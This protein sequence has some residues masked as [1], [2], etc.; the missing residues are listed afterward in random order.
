MNVTV[1]KKLKP[2]AILVHGVH[3]IG[4][5]N[6]PTEAPMPIFIGSEENDEIECA[7]L[8]K[9]EN[10]PDF[11]KQLTW[12]RDTPDLPYRTVVI[13][14]VDTL[15]QVA[16]KEILKSQNGKTMATAFGGYGKAYEKMADMFLDIRDDFLVPLREK[17]KMNIILLAHSEKNKHE[18]PMTNTSYDNYS[19]AIHKKI[20]PIF[21]DWVS[22]ILF[23]NYELFKST[24]ESDGKETLQGSGQRTIFCEEMPSHIA[25]NRYNLPSEIAYEKHGAWKI[26]TDHIRA[27]FAAGNTEVIPSVTTPKV[28][29]AIV[30]EPPVET[31]PSVTQ[32]EE[33]P[34][35]KGRGR[36]KS[37][38]VT[39]PP[40]DI[41][42]EIAK[43]EAAKL[44]NETPVAPPPAEP[45][46]DD[47]AEC[48]R[49]RE[50][51]DRLF[52]RMPDEVRP[53][54]TKAVESGKNNH[55][56]LLRILKKMQGAIR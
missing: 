7:R 13:D 39:P 11:I 42:A 52:N 17:K 3:G 46:L 50:E 43:R 16:Q 24:R 19:T 9:I 12:L 10:W 26:L 55:V 1:G 56:E 27:F 44:A 18:D 23:I 22:A 31:P 37:R 6:L 40:T 5:T 45:V 21:E 29:T 34:K 35:E 25:K 41:D 30:E 33:P 53:G 54:I 28:D 38:P 32:P 47:A 8:P 15:E 36:A 51:I 14:C 4:K 2:L 20:K 48:M 49:I